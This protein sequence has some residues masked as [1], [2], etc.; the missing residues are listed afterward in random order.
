MEELPPS[1]PVAEA[2]PLPLLAF[3]PDR[4]LR[5]AN[6]AMR[7]FAA[8][9]PEHLR[10]GAPLPEV[11]R[12]LAYRGLLGPGDPAEL[13]EEAIRADRSRTSRR[14]ARLPDGRSIEIH[15]APLPGGGF[16]AVTVDVTAL[17]AAHGDAASELR[18]LTEVVSALATGIAAF[19]RDGRLLLHNPAYPGL[20]GLPPGLLREGMTLGEI[21]A[22]LEER[23]EFAALP[24]GAVPEAL[25]LAE[26]R[27][28]SRFQRRRPTGEVI[29]SRRSVLSDGVLLVEVTDV[30]ARQTAEDEAR[31]RAAL[32]DAILD[33][34][35]H[36]VCVYGPEERVVLVNRAHRQMIGG[37]RVGERLADMLR[38]QAEAGAFGPGDPAALA[39]A[40]LALRRGGALE[41]IRRR[42][43]GLVFSHRIAP[44]PDGGHVSVVTDI[45]AVAEAEAEAQR[46]ADRLAAIVEGMPLGVALFDPGRRLVAVNAAGMRLGGLDPAAL[47]LGTPFEEIVARQVAAGEYDA[48]EAEA[49]LAAGRGRP[50]ARRRTRPDG[51]ILDILSLP[52]PD[53]G[54]LVTFQDVTRLVR[55]EAEANAQAALL[56]AMI[57]NT[58]AGVLRFDAESRLVAANAV[59]RRMEGLTEEDVAR[60]IPR[61][62]VLRRIAAR[63]GFAGGPVRYEE[64]AALPDAA[65]RAYRR[66]AADGRVLD[67]VARPMPD[68]GF[69]V[70]LND[71]TNLVEAEREAS[72][73][74]ALLQ[75]M[76]DNA[77]YGVALYDREHRFVA[78]NALGLAFAGLSAEEMRPGAAYAD[79]L[80][81][82][83]AKGEFP[84]ETRRMLLA[85]D[86]SRPHRYRRVTRDGRVLDIDS[87]PMPDGG[88][89]VSFADVTALVRAEEAEK[90][91]A[92]ALRAMLDNI[93][94]GVFLYDAE[95]RLVAAN[96]KALAL[97]GL[98]PEEAAPGTR[99]AEL[100]ELLAERGEFASDDCP[101]ERVAARLRGEPAHYLRTR[102][103][104]TL[105]DVNVA[106]MPDGGFIVTLTD[107]T[108]LLRAE[109]ELRRRAAM[110]S[111]MLDNMRHGLA[112]YDAESRLLAANPLAAK[113]TGLPP[114]VFR[115]GATLAELRAAQ[116]AL[117]EFSVEDAE[118]RALAD[119]AVAPQRYVRTRPDGTVVEVTTDR[120]PEGFFVRTYADV[121]EDRRIRADLEA[122]RAAAEAAARA[123]SRFLATMTH[124]LRTPLN[125]VIG[126]AD[127]L[128]TPQPSHEV[129][130]YAAII[131]DAGRD[132]LAL[133]DQIL[134]VA[135]SETA[136]LPVRAGQVDLAALLARVVAAKRG[137]AAAG[138]IAL[139]LDLPP[140][141]PEIVADGARLEQVLQGLLSNALKFTESGGKV[142]VSA[143]MGPEGGIAVLVADSGIGIP[144]DSLPRLFEP[145]A[146]LDEGRA[147]RY[148]GAGIGLYLARSIA[149]AMGM[150]LSLASRKGEGTVATLLIPPDLVL[151][152]EESRA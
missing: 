17:V 84:E 52:M 60:R 14:L 134:D 109:E 91:R 48:A 10:P 144:P 26:A 44:L 49:A 141:L 138:R 98:S 55:A 79:L 117:G 142:A 118:R 101:E 121:T 104:G 143:C 58:E 9:G 131:A 86:R 31:R 112:L 15:S 72:R 76:I 47:P 20:V 4:R 85:V 35:P 7:A 105:L 19:G 28:A 83:V 93:A 77:G 111:A 145:F 23:G 115:P 114:E 146:Q 22:L 29:E 42:R 97:T 27:A 32:L 119:L 50:V 89:V 16:L 62:E 36:G 5:L 130:E 150:R 151:P 125:A 88:F 71:V 8:A 128:K 100:L 53:G 124:E 92:E 110:Q 1:D 113:L 133:I 63:G 148:G 78:A 81:L 139:S 129:V 90:R 68:G 25:W 30:T 38:E 64:V 69:L 107:V 2:L 94:S 3:G 149:E 122:A 24:D 56:R 108:Q 54:F 43:D 11:A 39:E 34:L 70:T 40:E 74:A 132:L 152:P 126:F 67:V 127:L 57:D 18:R 123:K 80:A 95:H 51:T 96:R 102:P 140:A 21:V 45:T 147:R 12:L 137:V 65:P 6:A 13:A 136:G 87:K 75:A 116:I 46:Q 99:H 103:D 33:A 135:R 37:A 73:R 61:A 66:T 41:R 106:P 59:A 82:Q 120:T